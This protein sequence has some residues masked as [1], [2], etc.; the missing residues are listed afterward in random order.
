MRLWS[1]ALSGNPEASD[2]GACR[3]FCLQL[4]VEGERLSAT[5]VY[6]EINKASGRTAA[7]GGMRGALSSLKEM[8]R[9]ISVESSSKLIV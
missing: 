3:V 1:F 4:T 6:E 7:A 5:V 2:S 8:V 9:I